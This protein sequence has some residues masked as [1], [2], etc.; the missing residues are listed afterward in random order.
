[1]LV[2]LEF[3]GLMVEG[4]FLGLG[5]E[6]LGGRGDILIFRILLFDNTKIIYGLLTSYISYF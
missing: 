4:E 3:L 2:Q 6:C 1:M 5:V